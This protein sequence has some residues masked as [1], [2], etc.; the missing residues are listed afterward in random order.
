MTCGI[1]PS[2]FSST[3]SS[4]S[5]VTSGRACGPRRSPASFPFRCQPPSHVSCLLCRRFA[6]ST[7][8]STS[9]SSTGAEYVGH[10]RGLV[11]ER[12][13]CSLAGGSGAASPT[14]A[15]AWSVGGDVDCGSVGE[16]GA[17]YRHGLACERQLAA[18]P[19]Q[20]ALGR[21]HQRCGLA[22]EH[23]MVVGVTD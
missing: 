4:P 14:S 13:W 2:S 3:L 8:S 15:R 17:G 18:V 12:P 20:R 19:W 5:R 9:L 6:P 11:S 1:H 10:R 21:R 22:G 23:E 7:T 16:R